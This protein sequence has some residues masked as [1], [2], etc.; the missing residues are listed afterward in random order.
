MDTTDLFLLPWAQWRRVMEHAFSLCLGKGKKKTH[1]CLS[2]Q[3]AATRS[4]P[5]LRAVTV[6]R[7]SAL[8]NKGP[9]YP[10]WRHVKERK[11]CFSL[12]TTARRKVLSEISN[13]SKNF[14]LC[15]G[16]PVD[17]GLWWTRGEQHLQIWSHLPEVWTGER[18]YGCVLQ[19]SSHAPSDLIRCFISCIC[20]PC[21]LS[22]TISV[23]L[24]AQT[25]EE[26]LFGNNEE[27]PAFKEFLGILGDNIELQDF[28][29]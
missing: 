14:C 5:L 27:T 16:I 29:G 13:H 26:E 20:R 17:S 9:I 1:L 3:E 7:M 19:F 12:T 22:S 4:P 10:P 25:S 15:P 11:T 8:G 28:K 21:F 24:P 18:L 23:S 6:C 2:L